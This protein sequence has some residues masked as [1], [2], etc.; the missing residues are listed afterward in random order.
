MIGC[1]GEIVFCAGSASVEA[2][3]ITSSLIAGGCVVVDVE[4]RRVC[5][6]RLGKR[7]DCKR[8]EEGAVFDSCDDIDVGVS[9]ALLAVVLN[10]RFCVDENDE[11]SGDKVSNR[12]WDGLLAC[13]KACLYL[14]CNCA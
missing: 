9:V 1:S 4:F 14:A 5:C 2:A 6:C 7:R 11:D 8:G 13:E 3:L 12:S 10:D